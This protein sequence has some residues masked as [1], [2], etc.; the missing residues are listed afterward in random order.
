MSYKNKNKN[1]EPEQ[2]EDKKFDDY[3]EDSE[4]KEYFMFCSEFGPLYSRSYSFFILS[5]IVFLFLS[6]F[7]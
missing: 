4:R 2:N 7:L 6:F 5:V 1:K 3:A